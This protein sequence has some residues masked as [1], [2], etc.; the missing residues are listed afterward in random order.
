M[1]ERLICD[2]RSEIQGERCRRC[3][4][5][6]ALSRLTLDWRTV[7]AGSWGVALTASELRRGPGPSSPVRALRQAESFV[8]VG[9]LPEHESESW[10]SIAG[11]CSL[12]PLQVL[13]LTSGT[14]P[15]LGTVRHQISDLHIS[16]DFTSFHTSDKPP[17][18][19]ISTLK[20]CLGKPSV[21]R[22]L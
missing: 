11:W 7:A 1:W 2:F 12:E 22:P 20:L 5:H 8:I 16:L 4:Y 21:E 6:H 17:Q 10:G 14:F 13:A 19:D 9:S 15:Y 18:V 3:R